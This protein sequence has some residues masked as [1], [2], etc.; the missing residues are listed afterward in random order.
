MNKEPRHYEDSAV[1]SSSPKEVFKFADDH[2]KFSSHMN[3]SSWMMGGSRMETK[4]D[5]GK[6]QKVGSH[7]RMSGK[8]LGINLF[9]DEIITQHYPPNRKSWETIGDLNLLVIGHYRMGFEIEPNNGKS[10]L[11]VYI[12]YELPKPLRTRWLGYLFGAMYAKWCLKQMLSGTQ[13]HFKV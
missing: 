9:L 3:K 13:D 11:K 10:R 6:G 12:N 1:I 4:I 7:I 8:V 5:K 2:T